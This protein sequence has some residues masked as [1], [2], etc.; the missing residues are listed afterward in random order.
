MSDGS[1]TEWTKIWD[2]TYSQRLMESLLSEENLVPKGN[3]VTLGFKDSAGG[4]RGE[5]QAGRSLYILGPT[6]SCPPALSTFLLSQQRHA[7]GGLDMLAGV[8][9]YLHQEVRL[10]RA[11]G[12]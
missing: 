12:P 6:Y 11:Q 2:Q 10:P 7:A 9:D 4:K 8:L 1:G 3:P 5:G